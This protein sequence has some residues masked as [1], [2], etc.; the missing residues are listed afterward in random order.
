L[1][2]WQ[3]SGMTQHTH[4]MVQGLIYQRLTLGIKRKKEEDGT[5]QLI[6]DKVMEPAFIDQNNGFLKRLEMYD[7]YLME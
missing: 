7:T 6:V 3:K 4:P 5:S 1:A 2:E